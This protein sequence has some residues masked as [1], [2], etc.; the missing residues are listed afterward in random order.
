LISSLLDE[1]TKL[2]EPINLDEV[3]SLLAELD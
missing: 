2:E 1:N 3:E